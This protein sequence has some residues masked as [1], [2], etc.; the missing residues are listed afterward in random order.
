M[1]ISLNAFITEYAEFS[2]DASIM[3]IIKKLGIM[4]VGGNSGPPK[5]GLTVVNVYK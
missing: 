4:W 5:I 3:G 1:H 2:I